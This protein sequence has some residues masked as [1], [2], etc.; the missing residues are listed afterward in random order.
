MIFVFCF[1]C[2]RIREVSIRV[3]SSRKSCIALGQ[4]INYLISTS[5]LSFQG[6][7]RYCVP[8]VL[9]NHFYSASHNKLYSLEPMSSAYDICKHDSSSSVNRMSVAC[10]TSYNFTVEVTIFLTVVWTKLSEAQTKQLSKQLFHKVV[11]DDL[12]T[13]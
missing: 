3:I 10:L 12:F 4:I 13:S 8:S 6:T 7:T 5:C 11:F 2:A 9:M 1:N